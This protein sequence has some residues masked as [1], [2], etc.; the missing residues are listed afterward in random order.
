MDGYK[1]LLGTTLY[2]VMTHDNAGETLGETLQVLI[3][4]ID[5]QKPQL[6]FLQTPSIINKTKLYRT[7][8][9]NKFL[10]CTYLFTLKNNQ[11]QLAS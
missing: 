4:H 8:I 11:K 6:Y 9:S 3:F 10:A 5:V 1:R 2:F 7:I